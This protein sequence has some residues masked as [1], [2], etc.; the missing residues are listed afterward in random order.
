MEHKLHIHYMFMNGEFYRVNWTCGNCRKSCRKD[1]RDYYMVKD[2]IW[3][4]ANGQK[5]GMLCMDC[6]EQG[7]GR[8]LRYEDIKLCTITESY[9]P[10][11][12]DIIENHR[13]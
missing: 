12:M 8:K 7:L 11:T 13:K 6:L 9:N 10:Y 2:H 3:I 4:K 1:P 5:K